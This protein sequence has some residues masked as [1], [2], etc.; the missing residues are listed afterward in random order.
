MKRRLWTRLRLKVSKIADPYDDDIP[1][2]KE[3]ALENA[4]EALRIAEMLDDGPYPEP[5]VAG[6]DYDEAEV[7]EG[8]GAR[9]DARMEEVYVF[10]RRVKER[11]AARRAARR[12]RVVGAVA[13][14]AL[15]LTSGA[16][17]SA[18][19]LGTTGVSTLDRL[20]NVYDEIQDGDPY[21][22]SPL[23]VSTSDFGDT[24][25]D[26]RLVV[27]APVGSSHPNGVRLT[28][29]RKDHSIC[30][31]VLML[32]PRS[33]GARGSVT[34]ASPQAIVYGLK[35][36]AIMPYGVHSDRVGILT[37]FARKELKSLTGTGPGG[38]LNV[39]LSAPWDP[40]ILGLGRFRIFIA[41]TPRVGTANSVAR[42]DRLRDV[43]KY[44][45]IGRLRNRARVLWDKPRFGLTQ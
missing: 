29:F 44:D 9:I 19:I 45:L 43:S 13:V 22:H 30:M 24:P 32:A 31:A 1:S 34:C 8:M 16:G 17:A 25:G 37:G 18:L 20:L 41:T 36:D 35:A 23:G 12:R 14:G 33:V 21:L 10:T 28:A 38:V 11:Q 5:P 3:M 6:I 42:G 27:T 39:T 7:S 2:Y 15:V 26:K 4:E 40:S